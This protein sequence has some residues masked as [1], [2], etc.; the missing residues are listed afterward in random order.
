SDL[1]GS[2][3][4]RYRVVVLTSYCRSDGPHDPRGGADLVTFEEVRVG[5]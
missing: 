3:P 1:V 2:R 5:G 4:T